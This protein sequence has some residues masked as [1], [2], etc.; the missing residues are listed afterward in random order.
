MVYS[1]TYTDKRATLS[2]LQN[3]LTITAEITYKSTPCGESVEYKLFSFDLFQ[4]WGRRIDFF[5][6]STFSGLV[7]LLSLLISPSCIF[8]YNRSTSVKLILTLALT[9]IL[10]LIQAIIRNYNP[11]NS[12]GE[13]GRCPGTL[14][15]TKLR[16]RVQPWRRRF[17]GKV[18]FLAACVCLLPMR[19]MK[20][21]DGIVS[22]ATCQ[23]EK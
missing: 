2:T 9:Q 4:F 11:S 8:F 21:N 20:K 16:C 3:T 23:L 13:N 15:G 22:R 5:S 7:L 17:R 10:T 14:I 12:I 19:V 18:S 6:I 1:N